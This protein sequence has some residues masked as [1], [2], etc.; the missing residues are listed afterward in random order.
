MIHFL[1]CIFTIPEVYENRIPFVP[2]PKNAPCE[3]FSHFFCL[4]SW[5]SWDA[6]V[7]GRGNRKGPFHIEKNELQVQIRYHWK[8]YE[9]HYHKNLSIIQLGHQW[10]HQGSTGHVKEP[11]VKIHV[12]PIC[13]VHPAPKWMTLLNSTLLEGKY[14]CIGSFYK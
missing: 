10:Y 3:S 1:T 12:Q 8:G 6:K 14:T 11:L 5:I 9:L 4:P 2:I 13:L 7:R